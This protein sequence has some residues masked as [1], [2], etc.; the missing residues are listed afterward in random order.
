M[1]GTQGVAEQSQR[2]GALARSRAPGDH[3]GRMAACFGGEEL[4][5]VAE[6]GLLVLGQRE[7]VGVGQRAGC[8]VEQ[9]VRR[10]VRW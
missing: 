2:E 9:R 7:H 8:D 10:G 6:G 3:Q 5:G 4:A 1:R